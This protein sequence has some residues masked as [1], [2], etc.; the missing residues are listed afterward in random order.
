MKRIFA[1]VLALLLSI[2]LYGVLAEKT[3]TEEMSYDGV[4]VIRN[5]EVTETETLKLAVDYPSFVVDSQTLQDFLN[6]EISEPILALRHMEP[7]AAAEAYTQGQTDVIRGGYYASMEIEGLLSVE[8]TVSNR[9]AGSEIVDTSFFWRIVD[10]N[11]AR[12][13][14]ID[15]LFT[16]DTAEVELAIRNAV[17]AQASEKGALL[18]SVTQAGQAPMPDSYYITKEYLR[19]IYAAGTLYS[20]AV[21]VDLPWDSLPLTLSG[22]MNGDGETEQ[23]DDLGDAETVESNHLNTVQP[24]NTVD[25]GTA[26]PLESTIPVTATPTV[27]PVTNA[28]VAAQDTVVAGAAFS[29]PPVQTATPMPLNGNDSIIGDVL[30]HGLWKRLGTD[31]GTYYQFTADGKILTVTVSDYTL[32]G[33]VLTSDALSGTVDVGSDSAFTLYDAN[34]QPVGYVLNRMGD[35]VAPEE[36]VT[37]T[38]SPVPTDTPIPTATPTLAPTATPAPTPAPTPTLSPYM[39]A[40]SKAPMLAP[41]SDAQFA[42]RSTLQVYSAPTKDAFRQRN[43]QVTT[44][45]TVS[46]YGIADENWVLVSYEIG[47]GSKGRIGYIETSTLDAPETVANLHLISMEMT[48][49]KDCNGT[50][51]PILSKDTLRSFKAGEQVVLLA[52]MDSEW[53]YIETTNEG[54]PCRLFIPQTALMEE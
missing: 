15:E 12:S 2:P 46:I 7:M 6:Q 41:L 34:G 42:R 28:P 43:A 16:Q 38:P 19:A 23:S 25:A 9:A 37:P 35:A 45:E 27:V 4:A 47:S 53:A 3:E 54:K 8:A 51:D 52:F 26:T 39:E 20:D 30:T 5:H 48:L 10:L 50:D 21:V 24:E 49:T 14:T 33:G 31:G 13:V 29:L 32:E 40:L 36:L 22:L 44:D 11:E 1:L 17:Y 18:D